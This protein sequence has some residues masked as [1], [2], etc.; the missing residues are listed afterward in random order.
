MRV[1]PVTFVAAILFGLLLSSR[2]APT[3]AQPSDGREAAAVASAVKLKPAKKPIAF[4]SME[5]TTPEAKALFD[6]LSKASKLSVNSSDPAILQERALSAML[7]AAKLSL[8]DVLELLDQVLAPK[9]ALT[10]NLIK[11]GRAPSEAELKRLAKLERQITALQSLTVALKAEI[12]KLS[13]GKMP[14]VAGWNAPGLPTLELSTLEQSESKAGGASF[15]LKSRRGTVLPTKGIIARDGSLALV[16][17]RV[18]AAAPNDPIAAN[19]ARK[20]EVLGFKITNGGGLYQVAVWPKDKSIQD[21]DTLTKAPAWVSPPMSERA[22]AGFLFNQGVTVAAVGPAIPVLVHILA[23]IAAAADEETWEDITVTCFPGTQA[24]VKRIDDYCPLDTPTPIPEAPPTGTLHCIFKV[25]C[26]C[27]LFRGEHN[28][29]VI[30]N[31]GVQCSIYEY[32]NGRCPPM[33]E[34]E[35]VCPM[36]TEYRI[37]KEYPRVL[38]DQNDMPAYN[39]A[40]EALCDTTDHSSAAYRQIYAEAESLCQAFCRGGTLRTEKKIRC[41]V[42]G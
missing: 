27:C 17:A 1:R 6:E 29:P 18:K 15:V 36:Y 34:V 14:K 11:K 9:Q 3:L 22:L 25:A 40:V 38:C 23:E 19:D 12:K 32:P 31:N 2:I 37:N 33:D 21:T 41:V 7:R 5:A 10:K 20:A 16:I 24:R 8:R 30:N 39:K 26:A 13:S 42:R 4:V 35:G 28:K